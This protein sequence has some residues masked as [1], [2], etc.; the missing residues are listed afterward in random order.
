MVYIKTEK[1][2]RSYIENFYLWLAELLNT[3][4]DYK[5]VI[6][7]AKDK[8]KSIF[9]VKFI[10]EKVI[11]KTKF[12]IKNLFEDPW[13]LEC[14][15]RIL[16]KKYINFNIFWE[17]YYSV[18]SVDERKLL[19]NNILKTYELYP[20][21][22]YILSISELLNVNIITIHRSKYGSNK[23]DE[24]IVR[25]DIED[26]KLSSTF[27]KAPTN[28]ENRPLIILNKY[29]DGRKIIYNLVVDETLPLNQNIIYIKM[30]D[31]PLAVKYLIN[32]HIKV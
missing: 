18:I 21:D 20:N 27:Y 14:L 7:S 32:E 12:Q 16:D 28:Y 29:D 22:Y 26:L 5:D 17:K 23:K 2:D 31:V 1:Y 10:N 19:L 13:F 9:S 15:N 3:K 30:S 8:M 11:T 6:S 4:T 25:G 24:E